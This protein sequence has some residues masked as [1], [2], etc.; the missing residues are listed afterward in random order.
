MP[1]RHEKGE[2]KGRLLTERGW[3]P[4]PGP[5]QSRDLSLQH[6]VTVLCAVSKRNWLGGGG[7]DR[8]A[9]SQRWGAPELC[10]TSGRCVPPPC[11]LLR[12][13]L[14]GRGTAVQGLKDGRSR[15]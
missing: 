3:R 12:A 2:P 14:P 15:P 8:K 6:S 1:G 10:G 5:E 4:G 9:L 11:S 13:E 7:K